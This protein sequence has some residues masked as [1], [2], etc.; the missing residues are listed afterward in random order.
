MCYKLHF[1]KNIFLSVHQ[2]ASPERQA[3]QHMLLASARSTTS[4]ASSH[5][6]QNFDF[7]FL[8]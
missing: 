2:M 6:P 1:H 3:Q 7:Y 4:I 5:K 8:F